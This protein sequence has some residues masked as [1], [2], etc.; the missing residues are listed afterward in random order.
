MELTE[1]VVVFT[2]IVLVMGCIFKLAD[3]ATDWL[4]GVATKFAVDWLVVLLA[5]ESSVG[6]LVVVVRLVE[7]DVVLFAVIALVMDWIVEITVVVVDCI[8]EPAG[9]VTNWLVVSAVL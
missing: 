2:I 8:F 9:V 1:I 4:V 7:L 6:E 3:V 5:G